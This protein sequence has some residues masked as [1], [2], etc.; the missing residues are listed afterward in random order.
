MKSFNWLHLTD[1]HFGLQ[2]QASIWPNVR[3][4]FWNDLENLHEKSGPWDAVIFTGDLVQSGS[5]AEFTELENKVLGPLWD[6]LA[7]LGSKEPVLLAVPG[8]HDLLRPASENPKAALR[9]MLR[10]DG[11]SEIA[12]EFWTDPNSEYREIISASFANYQAWSQKNTRNTGLKITQGILP[13]DFSATLD[14][15][16]DDG[17]PLRI[18]IAGINTTFLQLAK[19]DYTKR[20]VLDSRQLHQ[21]C[22]ED[23][24]GWTKSHDACILMTHQGPDWLDEHSAMEAYT[25]INPAGR[26]AVHLF[27][28][29]H[30]NTMRSTATGGGK[31][32][33]QWQ[34]NSLFGL[35]KFG[36][37]PQTDRRHGYGAGRIEF[38][39]DGASIRHWPRRATKIGNNGW[40]FH[41][42]YGSCVLIEGDSCTKS[43]RLESWTNN[44]K[45]VKEDGTT[46]NVMSL[47]TKST[48]HQRHLQEMELQLKHALEAFKG[49]PTVFLEPKLSKTREFNDEPNKLHP[50]MEKPCDTLII[51][52]PEFGLTCLGLYLQVEAFKK[53]DFWLYIDAEKT[54]GRKI[55][56]LIDKELLHYD[57]KLTDL[58]CIILDSWD[59]DD[60]DHLTMAKHIASK[61][62]GLPLIILAEDSLLP[63]VTGNLSKLNRDFEL[64]HLQA[65]SR[66]SMRKLVAGYNETKCI[67][68]EDV[69]LSCVAGYLESINIH[70]TPL[71]CYTLLRVLDSS[72]SE[73]LLN[74]S[75]LLKAILFILFTDHDSF[76]FLND[77]PEV[78]ECAYVLGSFCSDL[79]RQRTR[80]FDSATLAPT[81]REICTSR[82]IVLDVDVM[83]NVLLENN[84]LVTNG[85]QTAFRHRYWIFYF[86]AEWMRHEDD[87]RQFVLHDRNYVNYPEI[88]EF[89]TGIDGRR[90]DALETILSDISLLTNQVGEKIGIERS[91]DPLSPLLWNPTE[92]YLQQARSK[93]AER[94]ESSNLPA[95]IKDKHADGNY[96]SAAPYDQGISSFLKDYS[97]SSLLHSIKAASCALRSSPFVK[98]EL[99]HEV[100]RAIFQA[101]EE[102]SRVVF[103]LSPILAKEGKA[104][105]DGFA[106]RL[107]EGF[108][109][110]LDKRFNQIIIANPSNIARIL[111]GDLA[112][113]KIC[114]LIIECFQSTDSLLQKHMMAL[115]LAAARPNGWQEAIHSYINLLHPRSFYLG[116]IFSRLNH[117]VTLGDLEQG[118]ELALKRLTRA[119]ISKR[120]YA[121]K[122]SGNKQIPRNRILNDKNKLPVDQLLKGNRKSW[123]SI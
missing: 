28:H 112:S 13:G 33:R 88:I 81:L 15:Q 111:G 5:E 54:K 110:D 14:V 38:D 91:F 51:A 55:S 84:I 27:G 39:N 25:E 119:I 45:C 85:H 121:P 31:I 77:K 118:E 71:N 65:L 92:E 89:Y 105:H 87:F 109:E 107:E 73:N 108:S 41:P 24:P 56:D 21:A 59:A 36:D 10:E 48:H 22:G 123:P 12:N 67:G 74:K 62:P 76:S 42:D 72:Y 82:G 94:V 2:G 100:A 30:E 17:M 23:L 32:V 102:I 80:Y 53:N 61:C 44:A 16:T 50:L 66:S 29:M 120:E 113:K 1:L 18:G 3:E 58:N 20:L 60:F 115:F 96:Q 63:D 26:F 117:E 40:G 43:E 78:E 104:I 49:Q 9:Q 70:R 11:F 99:R 93:I 98:L 7:K 97:V 35:E 64:L 101:W 4:V 86:A 69:I 68:T 52:P 114:P 6:H 8:N 90:N 37:P 122:L 46:E 75:K 57:H 83:L 103:W 19:G 79:V 116:D 95:E 106:V 47:A 34:G